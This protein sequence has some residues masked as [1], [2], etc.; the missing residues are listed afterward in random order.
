MD[1]KYWE[2]M[3]SL[4]EERALKKRSEDPYFKSLNAL[5]QDSMKWDFEEFMMKAAG[6]VKSMEPSVQKSKLRR[7][8]LSV[9]AAVA[10][11]IVGFVFVQ[12]LER[13]PT[14]LHQ[15]PTVALVEP[16]ASAIADGPKIMAQPDVKEPLP[17]L[18]PRKQPSKKGPIQEMA[19]DGKASEKQEPL[20]EEEEAYV[21]VNGKPVHDEAEAEEIV[22]ASLKIMAAN[23]QEGRNALEKVKYISVEL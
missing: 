16:S 3:S 13:E 20:H 19:I 12:S 8:W 10:L 22:L 23:F 2:G 7:V 6:D 9:A 4:E 17:R 1:D 21:I 11:L 5:S 14:Q 18:N 15:Q